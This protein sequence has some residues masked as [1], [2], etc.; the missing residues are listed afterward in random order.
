MFNTIR[1][2]Y[3]IV[4][5]LLLTALI[6]LALW[7]PFRPQPSIASVISPEPLPGYSIAG[8]WLPF[9]PS[10]HATTTATF[11]LPF[12]P[13]AHATTAWLPFRS[14]SESSA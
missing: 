12:R 13:S 9:R 11:W 8:W 4:T 3:R 10:A 2:T 7:L 6:A 5:G 1:S 14:G